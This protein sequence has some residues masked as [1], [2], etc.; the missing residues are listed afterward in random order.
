[1][2]KFYIANWVGLG[3]K[4][5]P[6]RPDLGV[7]ENIKCHAVDLKDGTCLARVSASPSIHGQ[8]KAVMKTD[9][10]AIKILQGVYPDVDLTCVD[11]PD[12]EVNKELQKLGYN[13][14]KIRMQSGGTLKEQEWGALKKIAKHKGKNIDDLENGIKSGRCDKH[15]EALNRCSVAAKEV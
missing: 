8:I 15:S 1:M 2:K 5:D 14:S 3:T 12:I 10:E 13:A 6:I 7:R 4:E 11:V 9:E